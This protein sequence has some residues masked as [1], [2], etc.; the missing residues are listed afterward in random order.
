MPVKPKVLSD[1]Q[2]AEIESLGALLSQEQIADYLSRTTFHA[3]MERDP[4]VAERY[5][6]AIIYLANTAPMR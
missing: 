4:D 3:I 6:R 5:K 1:V 2:R